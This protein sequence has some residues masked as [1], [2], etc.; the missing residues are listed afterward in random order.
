MVIDKDE[1]ED[2]EMGGDVAGEAYRESLT[3][4]DGFTRGPDG[5][6]KFNKDTKK[7]RREA[8]E[9]VEDVEMGDAELSGRKP[10]KRRSEPKLGREFKAKVSYLSI[11][12]LCDTNCLFRKRAVTSRKVAW[13]LTPTY[14]CHK[15]RKR[16]GVVNVRELLVKDEIL[17]SV[18]VCCALS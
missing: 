14:L 2:M 1:D 10:E 15:Q 11:H 5:R 7:R 12:A 13:I 9:T 18:S 3:S 17:V 8:D 6:V 16:K 4:V